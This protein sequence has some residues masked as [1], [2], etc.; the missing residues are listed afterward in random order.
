MSF[1]NE[2]LLFADR[3]DVSVLCFLCYW[4]TFHQ[5]QFFLYKLLFKIHHSSYKKVFRVILHSSSIPQ[6][7]HKIWFENH[8]MITH[9][10]K[11]KRSRNI[12]IFHEWN[13]LS[14]RRIWIMIQRIDFLALFVNN[15]FDMSGDQH[16]RHRRWMH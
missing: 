8:V 7:I 14:I 13:S 16:Q 10:K 12:V 6:F 3:C 9:K 4:F 2:L 11:T 1:V 5:V 15:S